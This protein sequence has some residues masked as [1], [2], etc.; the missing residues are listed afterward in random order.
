MQ[1]RTMER[2][3]VCDESRKSSQE[4]QIGVLYLRL[5]MAAENFNVN[6]SPFHINRHMIKNAAQVTDE[7]TKSKFYTSV[8]MRIFQT[9][10]KLRAPVY[11][12]FYTIEVNQPSSCFNYTLRAPSFHRENCSNFEWQ[13]AILAL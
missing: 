9:T 2:A 8:K 5:Q 1:S 13:F 6:L 4:V 12:Q 3:F 7:L 11:T 10:L